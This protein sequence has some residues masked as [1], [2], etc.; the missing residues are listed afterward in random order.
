MPTCGSCNGNKKVERALVTSGG[1]EIGIDVDCPECKGMGVTGEPG[2]CPT[3]N[4][5]RTTT[6]PLTL[7]SGS[8]MNI[9]VDCPDCVPHNDNVVI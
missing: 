4:G 3:C 5:S 8:S 1:G 6:R 9:E 7:S 2:A